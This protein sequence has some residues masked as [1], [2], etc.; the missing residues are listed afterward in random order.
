MRARLTP[1]PVTLFALTALLSSCST[2]QIATKGVPIQPGVQYQV[3]KALA[4]NKPFI[5]SQIPV[6]YFMVDAPAYNAPVLTLNGKNITVRTTAYCHLES[7]HIKYGRLAAA[8]S[9]LKFGE[10]CSA[11][12]D[13]SRYPMG[14][15]FRIDSQPD[16]VYEVDDYGSALVGSGTIDLYRPTTGTMDAW[17]VREVNIE[18]LQWGSFEDSLKLMR[19]RIHYPFVRHMVNDIQSRLDQKMART[20]PKNTQVTAMADTDVANPFGLSPSL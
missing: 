11:A 13:W 18:I 17:G 4:K 12:A 14:T 3:R 15:K 6:H 16:V 5:Q 2:S 1:F 10:I 20:E 9:H 8:G 7:D 19:G